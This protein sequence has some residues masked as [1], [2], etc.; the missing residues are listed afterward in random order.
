MTVG[1]GG[2]GGGNSSGYD[3]STMWL[4]PSAAPGSGTAI[5]IN[6]GGT[7]ITRRGLFRRGVPPI[8]LASTSMAARCRSITTPPAAPSTA[9]S[10]TFSLAGRS[11]TRPSRA[12][13][14][15]P[16][17]PSRPRAWRF[18]ADG[19]L[20]KIGLGTLTLNAADTYNG[21]TTLT[22]GTLKIGT[23]LALQDSIL[24]FNG[25]TFSFGSQTSATFGGLSDSQNLALTTRAPEPSGSPSA[26]ATTRRVTLKFLAAP[27]RR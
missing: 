14:T 11:S 22:A 2:G 21:P 15:T 27:G 26:A 25:G 6:T 10:S 23:P 13:R 16:S 4:N 19:G 24:T 3:S 1:V 18:G 20:T 9:F 7:L 5:N 8:I 12:A 17:S